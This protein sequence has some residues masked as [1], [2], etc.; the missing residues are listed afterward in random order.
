MGLRQTF[1]YP[2]GNFLDPV[3]CAARIGDLLF[4]SDLYGWDMK[5]KQIPAE[6]ISQAEALF[7]NAERLLQEAGGSLENII[8]MMVCTRKDRHRDAL[9]AFN[10]PWLRA[11]PDKNRRPARH[12]FQE[13]ELPLKEI[14]LRLNLVAV[15]GNDE[16]ETIHF[17]DLSHTN[18][19]PMGARRGRYVFSSTLFGAPSG[20]DS[21]TKTYPED[22]DEQAKIMFQNIT[23][24]MSQVHATPKDI[25]CIRLFL[26][27]GEQQERLLKS[28]DQEWVKLFPDEAERPARPCTEEVFVP[29]G[30]LFRA[31]IV[32]IS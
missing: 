1:Y 25:V 18:P 21:D 24:F 9:D 23:K 15:L 29:K 12:A 16:R 32:V 20:T 28:I 22:S 5:Q 19:I 7:E 14:L 17:T 31:E 27:K 4:S 26:R 8:Y 11:Y 6:A 3:P 13:E 30:M 10:R 2:G